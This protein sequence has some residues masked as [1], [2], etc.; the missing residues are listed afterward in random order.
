MKQI[1]REKKTTLPSLRNLDG[2]KSRCR[3]KKVW[4]G[5]FV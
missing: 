3:L 2:K 1:M 5:F 4:F